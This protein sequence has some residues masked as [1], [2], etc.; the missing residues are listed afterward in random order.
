[1]NQRQRIAYQQPCASQDD[2]LSASTDRQRMYLRFED[3]MLSTFLTVDKTTELDETLIFWHA[4]AALLNGAFQPLKLAQ[5]AEITK[6]L[7]RSQLRSML[8]GVGDASRGEFWQRTEY[9]LHLYRALSFAELGGLSMEF[10]STP[11]IDL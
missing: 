8:V 4:S 3:T 2:L 1:V 5:V 11:S 7:I 6:L 9:T 10:V